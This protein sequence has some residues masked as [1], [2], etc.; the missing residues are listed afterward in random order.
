MHQVLEEPM[1]LIFY[2]MSLIHNSQNSLTGH[3]FARKVEKNTKRLRSLSSFHALRD[4]LIDLEHNEDP[5]EWCFTVLMEIAAMQ[6]QN[7][8]RNMMLVVR[9]FTRELTKYWRRRG[10][11][12]HELCHSI[13]TEYLSQFVQK[14]QTESTLV[15]ETI[16]FNVGHYPNVQQPG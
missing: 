5:Q 16:T 9:G 2:S 14:K 7:L 15:V 4:H 10:R 8:D 12:A 13:A 6:E 3:L 11:A 1:L